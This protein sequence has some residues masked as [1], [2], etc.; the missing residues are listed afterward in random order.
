[1]NILLLL[2]HHPEEVELVVLKIGYR[3]PTFV[4][5]S[6]MKRGEVQ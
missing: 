1:M 4:E 3:A 6:Y 2:C 5:T